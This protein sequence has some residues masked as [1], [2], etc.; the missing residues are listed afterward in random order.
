MSVAGEGVVA[1]W[2]DIAP[3][4]RDAFYA[5]HGQEHMPERV[6]I[7]GFLRGRRYVAVEADLEFF[8]L[9]DV[10]STAVLSG[11]AYRARLNSPTPWTIATV[12]H[13][14]SVA[15]SLC[16]VAARRSH[17][18]AYGGLV[19]TLRYDVAPGAEAAHRTAVAERLL[20]ALLSLP[21]VA[22]GCLLVADR[23]AS[24]EANAEQKARGTPN[25]VP[26]YV[27]LVEGW[28]DAAPF[29]AAMAEALADAPLQSLGAT[30]SGT[31]GIY[32]HQV[33]CLKPGP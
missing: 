28:G 10:D 26:P 14:R 23:T 33:T 25:L 13:F 4:G 32:R 21:G 18:S 29:A 6:A 1:I 30:G 11:D 16:H 2:H 17:G 3:E 15:R 31:L 8:N 20:P 19:A 27:L 5:W 7:P 12:R 24:G 22:G 9:Y